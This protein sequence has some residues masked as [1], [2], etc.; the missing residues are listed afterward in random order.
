MAAD[1]EAVD[2]FDNLLDDVLV[3]MSPIPQPDCLAS[4]YNVPL[5]ATRV[6]APGTAQVV[7]TPVQ[8][9]G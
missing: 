5:A 4:T 9:P 2:E 1:L 6:S 7:S 8:C 3:L